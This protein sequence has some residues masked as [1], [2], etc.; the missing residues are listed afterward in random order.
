MEYLQTLY[1]V[2]VNSKRRGFQQE[3]REKIEIAAISVATEFDVSRQTSKQRV[4]ELCCNNILC[5][6]TQD[7]KIGI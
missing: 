1:F 7:L 5:V 6:T 4:R 3:R 2:G